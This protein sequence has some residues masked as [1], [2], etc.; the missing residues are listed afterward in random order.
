MIGSP[1]IYHMIRNCIED[2]IFKDRSQPWSPLA[3]TL[4][5]RHLLRTHNRAGTANR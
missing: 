2:H 3:F 4:T 1:I 5:L